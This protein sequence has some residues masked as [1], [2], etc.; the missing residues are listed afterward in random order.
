M[1]PLRST[2]TDRSNMYGMPIEPHKAGKLSTRYLLM[3]FLLRQPMSP[4]ISD[5]MLH[6]MYAGNEY[7]Q[8]MLGARRFTA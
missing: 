8:E 1:V 7:V 6:I 5:C 3:L 2:T 4:F